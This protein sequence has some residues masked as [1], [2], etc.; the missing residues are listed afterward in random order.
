MKLHPPLTACV[1]LVVIPSTSISIKDFRKLASAIIPLADF[2]DTSRIPLN[3]TMH[4]R[5]R[6]TSAGG[7]AK[8]RISV[9]SPLS[10]SSSASLAAS[11]AGRASAR[12]SS[13]SFYNT[14]VQLVEFCLFVV[15]WYR[16]KKYFSFNMIE[17]SFFAQK[18]WPAAEHP[19]PTMITF[20]LVKWP[21]V[22]FHPPNVLKPEVFL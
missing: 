22:Y 18:F 13:A 20:W 16:V 3:T 15:V 14:K 1:C 4:S 8:D 5:T 9:T 2:Q 7:L 10:R 19:G 17:Y 21:W 6:C 11:N 12:E